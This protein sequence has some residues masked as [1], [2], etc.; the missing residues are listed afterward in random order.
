MISPDVSPFDLA[1]VATEQAS[2]GHCI[3][4][5]DMCGIVSNAML[6]TGFM[7]FAAWA[8]S[9]KR[10]HVHQAEVRRFMENSGIC[11]L[12]IKELDVKVDVV[13]CHHASLQCPQ[14]IPGNIWEGGRILYVVVSN[15]VYFGGSHSSMRIDQ[16]VEYDTWLTPRGDSND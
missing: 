11:H 8:K 14:K 10:S 16:R 13:G 12:E 9:K 1:Q 6:L 7:E 4:C 5:C 3:I 15:A 2:R